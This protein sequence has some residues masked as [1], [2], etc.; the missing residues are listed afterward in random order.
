MKNAFLIE[1]IRATLKAAQITTSPAIHEATAA[2][3][4]KEGTFARNVTCIA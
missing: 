4:W 2:S 1:V 3:N